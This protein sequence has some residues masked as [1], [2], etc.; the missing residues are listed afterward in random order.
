MHY[1]EYLQATGI[2]LMFTFCVYLFYP[3]L[4]PY[5]KSFGLDDFQVSLIFAVLPLAVILTS[6]IMGRLADSIGRTKVIIFGLVIEVTALC[7]YIF[8]TYWWVVTI[9]RFLDAAAYTGATLVAIAKIEDA[10]SDK[11]RGKYAGWSFSLSHIGAIVA[12]VVGGLIADQ[13]FLKAPF[14]VSGFLLLFLAFLLAFKTP[15]LKKSV[16]KSNFKLHHALKT[17]LDIYPLK[18]MAIL[19]MVMH[20]TRPAF[21]VFLPLFIFE[22]LGL[23]YTYIGIAMFFFGIAH[24]FQFYFGHLNNKF[25]RATMTLF[26][27]SVFAFFMFLLSTI[28][29]YYVLLVFLFFLGVGGAIW[30]VSAWTLMSDIG[31]K[32]GKEGEIVG[33]Y[34]SLAK[35]GS[36]VSFLFSGLIVQVYNMETLFIVNSFL[37]AFGILIAS[38]FFAG[39]RDFAANLGKPLKNRIN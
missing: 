38:F 17:F 30:N 37:V 31:E 9:A 3:F 10:L 12:P 25:G 5:I 27:C 29:S 24:V 8:G 33:S 1:R 26:G 28:Q 21:L 19:G 36:F 14:L 16:D 32:I 11:E 23:S 18:G 35:M 13:F 6:P 34:M 4:S 15:H 20:A 7:L 2:N 39:Y 22:R